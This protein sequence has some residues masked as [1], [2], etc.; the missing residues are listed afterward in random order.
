MART[1]VATLSRQNTQRMAEE[2]LARLT[3]RQ[4]EKSDM[5]WPESDEQ[6]RLASIDNLDK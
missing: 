3:G 1:V 6:N 5:G 4:V 2:Q